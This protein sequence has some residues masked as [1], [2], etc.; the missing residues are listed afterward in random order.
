ME[1]GEAVHALAKA[2]TRAG[3]EWMLVGSYSSNFHG[4]PRSTKDADFVIQCEHALIGQLF[5]SLPGELVP[6]RQL[7][8]E[9]VTGTHRYIVA[10][11][12]STF[13]IELFLL[14]GEPHD[15]SRFARRIK[16]DFEGQEVFVA[17]A[18]DV[19]ITKLRWSRLG[20]RAKD[21]DDVLKVMATQQNRLDWDYIRHWCE[22]HG[23]W[24][25]ATQIR[26]S[27]PPL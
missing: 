4:V 21:V 15:Q 13:K 22:Q 10:V 27:I 16:V 12:N 11:R 14:S 25:L 19:I 23:T 24:E 18:E 26:D 1:G 17:S 8:F 5:A 6:D 7:S 20:R 3:I 2:L 9:G